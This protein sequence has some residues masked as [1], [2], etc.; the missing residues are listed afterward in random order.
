MNNENQEQQISRSPNIVFAK[1]GLKVNF[2]SIFSTRKI[3]FH[4]ITHFI[5]TIIILSFLNSCVE[6]KKFNINENLNEFNNIISTIIVYDSLNVSKGNKNNIVLIEDFKKKEI[7]NTQKISN[8][9]LPEIL[10]LEENQITLNSLF[11][12]GKFENKKLGFNKKD[13]LYLL[14][15][16]LNPNSLKLPNQ[17]LK[18][19]ENIKNKNEKGKNSTFQFYIPIIS[20]DKNTAYVELDYNCGALCGR[21]T[22]YFLNKIDGKWVIIVKWRTW[23]S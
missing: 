2:H 11:Y 6:D 1:N 21:G 23:I 15:Q 16:N 17:I 20:E 13:S 22:S 14:S 5:F 9:E 8:N 3:T 7:I 18:I 4:K 10:L 12:F 19:T